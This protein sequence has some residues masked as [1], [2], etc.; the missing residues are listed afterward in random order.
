MADNIQHLKTKIN[1]KSC[2]GCA[3]CPAK[4]FAGNSD[5]I[6]YGFGN[7]YANKVIILPTYSLDYKDGSYISTAEILI[8]LIGKKIF[9]DYYVTR[10]IKC[11]N[12]SRYDVSEACRAN[13]GKYLYNELNN[14]K[15][16]Y[17][18]AFGD[19]SLTYVPN[20]VLNKY[21][22]KRYFNPYCMI[23]GNDYLKS[24]LQ[25]QIKEMEAL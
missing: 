11:Y 17:I 24:K 10:E 12:L 7:I 1:I 13:C 25:E 16:N 3:N 20:K 9:E 18:F 6:T 4:L 23:A 5:L 19:V 15:A 14:L 8:N 21:I 2:A 22:I